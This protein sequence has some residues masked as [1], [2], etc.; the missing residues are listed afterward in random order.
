M[1]GIGLIG[2]DSFVLYGS[3]VSRLA[4]FHGAIHPLV[5]QLCTFFEEAPVRGSGYQSVGYRT[6]MYLG[7]NHQC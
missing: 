3:D 7:I 5:R 4:H 6:Y 1:A 2:H